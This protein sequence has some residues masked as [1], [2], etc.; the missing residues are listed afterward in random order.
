MGL[1]HKITFIPRFARQV[2]YLPFN[3]YMFRSAGAI[4]GKGFHVRNRIY[5]KLYKG[6]KLSIGDYFSVE[7]GEAINP[8]GRNIKACVFVDKGACLSIGNHVGM[9]SSTIWCRE[10]IE[11]GNNVKIGACCT[12]LDTDCH[13]LNFDY[14]HNSA[15]D[16]QNT[17]HKPVRIEDDVLIGANSIILKGTHIGARSV[18]GA[19]SVVSGDIP[20][21]CIA[22]GNPCTVLRYINPQ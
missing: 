3:K 2:F 19:G 17:K 10:K 7:S 6:A 5:L 21:D 20:S 12:I 4:I 1:L 8:I 16:Y 9:S 14:R 13:S 18:I 15:K 11:I 22:V